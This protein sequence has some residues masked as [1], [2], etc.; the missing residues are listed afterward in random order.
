MRP[1]AWHR[2][3]PSSRDSCP[4]LPPPPRPSAPGH[5]T[6]YPRTA[7]AAPASRPGSSVSTAHRRAS[8]SLAK[9]VANSK[10]EHGARD[11]FARGSRTELPLSMKMQMPPGWLLLSCEFSSSRECQSVE[12]FSS[13]CQLLFNQVRH[14]KF[15]ISISASP[16]TG[17]RRSSW[18]FFNSAFSGAGK[19]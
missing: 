4:V 10:Q 18:P 12:S 13:C 15:V 9:P 14:F 8:Q 7:P 17:S 2:L 16:F 19:C 5:R 1:V 11:W 3:S 6:R